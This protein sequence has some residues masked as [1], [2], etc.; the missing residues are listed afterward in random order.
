MQT[1]KIIIGKKD[2]SIERNVL[3]VRTNERV[4]NA[5]ARY[6]SA[7]RA[8]YNDVVGI[9]HQRGYVWRGHD[10]GLPSTPELDKWVQ[11][12]SGHSDADTWETL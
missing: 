3:L 2:G 12:N 1:V 5:I 4:T 6:G 10:A 9:T 8:S 7:R 11:L